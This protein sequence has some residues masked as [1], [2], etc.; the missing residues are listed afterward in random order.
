VIDKWKEG[1]RAG[2]MTQQIKALDRQRARESVQN[3]VNSGK[4]LRRE[5]TPELPSDLYTHQ[6]ICVSVFVS[7]S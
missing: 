7:L 3:P 2:K 4:G 1:I 5:Q 6:G